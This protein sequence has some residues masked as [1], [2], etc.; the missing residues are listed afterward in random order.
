MTDPE[1]FFDE[2]NAS[3][4]QLFGI[5]YLIVPSGYYPPVAAHM[6][7]RSGPYSLWTVATAG[8]VHVGRIVGTLVANRSDIGARAIPVLRSRLAQD[9]EY[10]D[11]AFGG[12]DPTIAPLPSASAQA[13]VGTVVSEVDDLDRGEVTTTV[14]MRH[15]GAV[16]LSASF[17]PG[18]AVTVDGRPHATRMVAPA[19]VATRVPAGTHTVVFR[20]RG[21]GHYLKLFALCALTLAVLL[22]ADLM[23]G[24]R[25]R[26][27]G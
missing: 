6:V 24:T 9:G 16:V 7:M 27:T 18:W 13:P 26:D 14:N 22:S 5:H 2:R 21:Y 3:D 20:Y 23:R 4:Y 11:V 19:L 12:R 8:Y 15:G 17:D 10:L 1:Y 25:R